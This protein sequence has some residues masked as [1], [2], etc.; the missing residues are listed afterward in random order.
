MPEKIEKL[1]L[2]REKSIKKLFEALDALDD[3]VNRSCRRIKVQALIDECVNLQHIVA[4]KNTKLSKSDS[5]GVRAEATA[6]A[7][8]VNDRCKQSLEEACNYVFAQLSPQKVRN[9]NSLLNAQ[10]RL[11]ELAP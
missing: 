9:Q 5:E 10:K 7:E 4:E 11:V 1:L 2:D 6:N 8:Q 3:N